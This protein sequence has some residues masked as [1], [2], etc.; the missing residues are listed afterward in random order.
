MKCHLP[1]YHLKSWEEAYFCTTEKNAEGVCCSGQK[2][3][4]QGINAFSPGSQGRFPLCCHILSAPRDKWMFL[5]IREGRTKASEVVVPGR[6]TLGT[7]N[8]HSISRRM[9]HGPTCL[10]FL[11]CSG[12]RAPGVAR[13]VGRLGRWWEIPQPS[14][15]N[16]GSCLKLLKRGATGLPTP[17]MNMVIFLEVSGSWNTS[18]PLAPLAPCLTSAC[19]LNWKIIRTIFSPRQ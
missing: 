4:T 7:L 15:T 8:T 5:P 11:V 13:K 10:I 3:R 6:P 18:I 12:W 16:G 14:P 1:G 19:S 9:A 2:Q 17:A